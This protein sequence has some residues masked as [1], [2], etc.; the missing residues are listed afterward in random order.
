MESS[1][2]VTGTE[3][4]VINGAGNDEGRTCPREDKRIHLTWEVSIDT[5]WP[6]RIVE[7]PVRIIKLCGS[8]WATEEQYNC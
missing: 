7:T 5:V 3:E 8:R 1:G 4:I 6:L 2:Q